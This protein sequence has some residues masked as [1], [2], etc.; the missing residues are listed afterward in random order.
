MKTCKFLSKFFYST[1]SFLY[2]K[3]LSQ[4]LNCNS[5]SINY[6]Y[7]LFIRLPA[8]TSREDV[9]E[10]HEAILLGGLADH[11]FD[12]CEV[13]TPITTL[14]HDNKRTMKLYVKNNVQVN[15]PLDRYP[16]WEFVIFFGPSTLARDS[17]VGRSNRCRRATPNNP[18]TFGPTLEA[19]IR[20]SLRC[21]QPCWNPCW[22]IKKNTTT[23]NLHD[24][25]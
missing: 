22:P 15:C 23:N 7:E 18:Q 19:C 8:Q 4:S 14:L 6:R 11:L 2:N 13:F 12:R 16:F 24:K 3:H 25:M 5:T 20:P 21:C 9:L 1:N 10:A 17:R